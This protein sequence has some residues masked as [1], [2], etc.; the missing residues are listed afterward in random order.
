MRIC[1]IGGCGYVGSRL[2]RHLEKSHIVVSYDLEL[3]GNPG[4]R[5]NIRKDYRNLN[6]FRN[7][8]AVI[9]LAGHSSV[10]ACVSDPF[11]AISNNLFGPIELAQKLDRQIFIYASSASVYSS[12]DGKRAN[13]YDFT[14]AACDEAMHLVHPRY[15]ALRFG[16]VCGPSP[17]IRLDLMLNGMVNDAM[18]K[19]IVTVRNPNIRRPLLGL[20]DLCSAVDKCL[21]AEP[22][23]GPHNLCSVNV[24]V[25]EVADAVSERLN[26]SI[27]TLP[28]TEA[29]NF[30]MQPETWVG[31][32][33]TLASMIDE[34]EW[35]YTKE[36]VTA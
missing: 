26:V 23:V 4:G 34:L 15:Y 30:S 6:D 22:S 25:G 31:P 35:F 32:K 33:E 18:T 3:R 12:S 28:D 11:G 10:S 21:R 20:S 16:T 36:A 24:T 19:G 27:K 14:K 17:N 5:R 9:L 7:F 13:V 2:Y 1:I 29:Y 8:D